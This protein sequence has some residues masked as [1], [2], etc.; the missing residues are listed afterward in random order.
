MRE[1]SQKLNTSV[2]IN[3]NGSVDI[4]LLKSSAFKLG[5]WKKLF[6]DGPLLWNF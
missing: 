6:M 1:Y 2:F 3:L 4:Q 5:V